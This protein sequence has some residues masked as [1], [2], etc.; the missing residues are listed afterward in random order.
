M[1]ISGPG[2]LETPVS[3]EG[4]DLKEVSQKHDELKMY[5]QLRILR[6]ADRNKQVENWRYSHPGVD[7]I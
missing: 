7:R 6:I 4:A 1:L 2:F 5:K 3:S